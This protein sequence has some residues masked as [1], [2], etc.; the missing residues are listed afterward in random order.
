M[1]TDKL[2]LNPNLPVEDRVKD[3]LARMTLV[4]KIAQM[5][6]KSIGE[7]QENK[8]YRVDL[9]ENTV[10]VHGIGAIDTVG[11]MITLGLTCKD[12]AEL[13]SNI[14]KYLVKHTRLGIPAF[15]VGEGLHGFVASEGTMYPQSI[16]VGGTFNRDLVRKMGKT[17]A[18][19][20]R[21]CG[22]NQLFA[23]NL[24]IAR[25]LRWGRVE[26]TYGEDPYLIGE[27]GTEYV[28]GIQGEREYIG[29]ENVVATLKHFVAHGDPQGGINLAPVA[30]G[31]RLL[32]ELY[33]KPF[34]KVLKNT[35][36]L[37]IMPAYSEY[38]GVPVTAS[39]YLLRKILREELG[40][41]GYTV[42]DYGAIEMLHNFHLTAET[43][44]EAGKQ[45]IKAGIDLE[46]PTPVGYTKVF[47][48]RVEKGEIDET[49]I[50]EA[51]ANILR[52][53]FLAGLFE[54]PFG[55]SEEVEEILNCQEH[56]TLAYEV[57]CESIVLL[58]N[59]DD[60]L[61]LSKNKKTIAV[62]GPNAKK[63]QL[64]DYATLKPNAMSLLKGLELEKG[65][66]IDILYHEGCDLY[67][68]DRSQISEA[69]GVAKQADMVIVAVG[70]SSMALCGVGWGS[71]DDSQKALCGEG[72]D[73]TDLEL[74]GVQQELV[75]ALIETNK[76]LITVLI[77]GRP[78]S[79]TRIVEKSDA[80]IEAWYPGEEG[81]RALADI[82]FGKVNPSGKLC[83]SVPKTV[84]QT[85]VYY[86]H[87][88]SARGRFYRKPGSLEEP[89]RDYV[90]MDTKA[91]FDFGFGL[92][93]T[94]FQYSKMTLSKSEI[95]PFEPVEIRITV[96]NTGDRKGKESVLLFVNDLYSSV[97]TPIQSL[98]GFEKIEL[99]PQEEKVV[100]F[101]I[102]KEHLTL[103]D[104]NMEEIVESGKFEIT[105]GSE[106]AI[107]T[108]L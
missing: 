40:F 11:S 108:V 96:K 75:D 23:P 45:A 53:K 17:I 25:E 7:F 95:K 59:K 61:P 2:Y 97:T 12:I 70:E 50:D 3:L 100:V 81:G 15:I 4:E 52:V 1:N 39:P 107:L 72:Y 19:E 78:L 94:T 9:A 83:V 103:F 43:G 44:E 80:V 26:E 35:H 8:L 60:I 58:K 13:T 76:P 14:Q 86:N 106:Q 67:S 38:D 28:N 16:G 29:K 65:D 74:P 6:M 27:L 46:A 79:V 47:K 98:C 33:L 55:A 82:L 68:Q 24:D 51:V 20:A 30:G 34:K 71:E 104:A 87:K 77:N 66:E 32:R 64:G 22:V 88:P 84:G 31:E 63:V 49:L 91:L 102:K 62:I 37:S 21:C 101:T 92:S 85:P 18:K 42:S 54:N 73:R 93:Y 5:N 90:F 105:C 48:D 56:K 41:R 10:G 99:E 36:V 57:A 69:I 89:G